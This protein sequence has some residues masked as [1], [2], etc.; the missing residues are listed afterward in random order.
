[1]AASEEEKTRCK[2]EAKARLVCRLKGRS[3][4]TIPPTGPCGAGGGE[5]IVPVCVGF[6]QGEDGTNGVNRL[7]QPVTGVALKGDTHSTVLNST[8]SDCSSSSVDNAVKDTDRQT[9][10]LCIPQLLFDLNTFDL[11]KDISKR[12]FVT[13][14]QYK[15]AYKTACDFCRLK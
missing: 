14:A 5:G 13:H 4:P 12:L 8:N 9:P 1:M 15:F 7:L 3:H 11:K 10:S 6:D 2:E